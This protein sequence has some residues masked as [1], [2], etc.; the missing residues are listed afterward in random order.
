M[1]PEPKFRRTGLDPIGLSWRELIQSGPDLSQ[2]DGFDL[3][4]L[5]DRQRE[6]AACQR[7]VITAW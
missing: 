1:T 4:H 6:H 3:E 7:G 5:M 2:A